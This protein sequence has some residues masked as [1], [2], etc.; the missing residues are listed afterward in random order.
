MGHELVSLVVPVPVWHQNNTPT[1][2]IVKQDHFIIVLHSFCTST[3]ILSYWNVF[4]YYM[5]NI[6]LLKN[7]MSSI[8]ISGHAGILNSSFFLG[9]FI[10]GVLG[11]VF[12]IINNTSS[13]TCMLKSSV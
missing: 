1:G 8:L 6:A 3:I 13:V 9:L 10:D 12:D 5:Y 4:G 7:P 11:M 2:V